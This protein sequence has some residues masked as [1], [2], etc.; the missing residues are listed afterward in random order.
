METLRRITQLC[1]SKCWLSDDSLTLNK[2]PNEVE[3]AIELN[4]HLKLLLN[5]I[6]VYID[7]CDTDVDFSS[8]VLFNLFGAP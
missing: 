5:W 6:W 4:L 1:L 8:D 7:L 3:S 2:K